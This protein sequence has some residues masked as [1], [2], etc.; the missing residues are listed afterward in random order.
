[1][2]I[3]NGKVRLLNDWPTRTNP[4]RWVTQRHTRC[5]IE[6]QSEKWTKGK[7]RQSWRSTAQKRQCVIEEARFHFNPHSPLPATSIIQLWRLWK[8]EE[9]AR[10]TEAQ[11]GRKHT[12]LFCFVVA[13]QSDVSITPG[14]LSSIND[15]GK[16]KKELLCPRPQI[17]I[18]MTRF[19]GLCP[20]VFWY[21][22]LQD[23]I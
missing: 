21:I 22:S 14:K 15:K 5:L 20:P 3:M 9:W 10:G 8:V 2:A 19:H 11:W 16:Q 7:D 12:S 1:M 4:K 23:V 18:S 13:F 17:P 6:G